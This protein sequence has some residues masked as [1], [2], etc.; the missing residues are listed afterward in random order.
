MSMHVYRVNEGSTFAPLSRGPVTY[1][2]DALDLSEA[3]VR[4]RVALDKRELLFQEFARL[5][6]EV[7]TGAG[8]GLAIS[9]RIARALGGEITVESEPGVGSKFELWLPLTG[10]REGALL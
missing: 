4:V 5:Q 9:R 1:Q 8:I 3:T 6:P 10:P 2:G 7:G